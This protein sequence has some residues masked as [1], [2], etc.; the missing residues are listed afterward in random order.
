M[1][2]CDINGGYLGRGCKN[3]VEDVGNVKC[4]C[5]EQEDGSVVVD[6]NFPHCGEGGEVPGE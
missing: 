2:A 5:S 6:G 1:P 4:F 3:K